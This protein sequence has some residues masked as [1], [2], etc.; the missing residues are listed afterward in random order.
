MSSVLEEV[1]RAQ[2]LERA[3]KLGRTIGFKVREREVHSWTERERSEFELH[4]EHLKLTGRV[5]KDCLSAPS[6]L[7]FVTHQENASGLFNLSKAGAPFSFISY[8]S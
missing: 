3:E 2:V 1:E 8:I 7:D 4:N 5:L 6:N